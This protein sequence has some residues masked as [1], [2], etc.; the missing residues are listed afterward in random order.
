MLLLVLHGL[1]FG[2]TIP[3]TRVWLLL[4]KFAVRPVFTSTKATQNSGVFSFLTPN[5]LWVWNRAPRQDDRNV[6]K[7][8]TCGKK[9]RINQSKTIIFMC[10]ALNRCVSVVTITH[11]IC[12]YRS[13]RRKKRWTYQV[14]SKPSRSYNETTICESASLLVLSSLSC[15]LHH[16]NQHRDA[17]RMQQRTT[18][19]FAFQIRFIL[20]SFKSTIFIQFVIEKKVCYRYPRE[21]H[22]RGRQESFPSNDNQPTPII[23]IVRFEMPK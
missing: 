6:Q 14:E 2:H 23:K 1:S 7:T 17:T 9:W 19:L 8:Q 10:F 18:S 20:F 4:H 15:I 16:G 13:N 5:G 12:C 3:E 21:H 22:L 11:G